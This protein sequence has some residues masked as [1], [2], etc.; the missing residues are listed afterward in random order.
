MRPLNALEELAKAL[1]ARCMNALD[2]C[3]AAGEMGAEVGVM[4]SVLRS[5]TGAEAIGRRM[6][7]GGLRDA[8]ADALCGSRAPRVERSNV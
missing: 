5:G 8:N 2:E 3:D 1:A 7:T 4:I 6:R